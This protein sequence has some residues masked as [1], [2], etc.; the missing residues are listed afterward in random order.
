MYNPAVVGARRMLCVNV[1]FECHSSAWMSRIYDYGENVL[2]RLHAVYLATVDWLLNG[3]DYI[4]RLSI[5]PWQPITDFFLQS[6]F[7][8]LCCVLDSKHS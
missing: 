3:T 7:M 4:L 8:L 5:D 6:S 2:P 1:S